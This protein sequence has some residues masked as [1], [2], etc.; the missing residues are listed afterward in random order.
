MTD[1]TVEHGP[2]NENALLVI[3]FMGFF[4][5]AWLVPGLEAAER[6]SLSPEA[7]YFSVLL[8]ITALVTLEALRRLD[9]RARVTTYVRIYALILLVCFG[10]AIW[11]IKPS[12]TLRESTGL[13]FPVM[14]YVLARNYRGPADLARALYRII[15][16]LFAFSLLSLILGIAGGQFDRL[17]SSFGEVGITD[18]QG[19]FVLCTVAVTT[20]LFFAVARLAN[21]RGGPRDWIVLASTTAY[22]VMSF[23]KSYFLATAIG[24]VGLYVMRARR[25]K[26]I[27]IAAA[28][29]GLLVFVLATDNMVSRS[30]F[31]HPGEVTV[32]DFTSATQLSDLPVNSSGRFFMWD[33]AIARA[34]ES[35]GGTWLGTGWGGSRAIMQAS[36]FKET[37]IHGD[38]PRLLVEMGVVG[39]AA[40]LLL[41]VVVI[42]H[43]GALV[44]RTADPEIAMHASVL[45]MLLVYALASGLTYETINKYRSLHVVIA[46]LVAEIGRRAEMEAEA[47]E[48]AHAA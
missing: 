28:S 3:L 45:V 14:V 10:S 4:S 13:L 41:V 17:W 6:G 46:V 21:R 47:G 12:L 40:Y 9:W 26:A 44:R 15:T 29:A 43:Y 30:F 32:A 18:I 33:Y 27:V 19:V 42:R 31:W 48:G 39:L 36:P 1:L 34:R 8:V 22:L 23:S 11:S 38:Y 5:I 2:Q 37:Y 25:M 7:I 20:S 35:V 16:V 24:V